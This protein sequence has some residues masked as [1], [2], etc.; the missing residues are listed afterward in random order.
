MKYSLRSLMEW[1]CVVIGVAVAIAGR[2]VGFN[3]SKI[4]GAA[5]TGLGLYTAIIG[6]AWFNR[7]PNSSAPAPKSAQALGQEI[8]REALQAPG[9]N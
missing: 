9:A 5:I 1:G 3:G 6:F 4:L 7:L 8:Q 2:V